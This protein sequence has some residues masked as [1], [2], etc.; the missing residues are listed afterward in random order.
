MHRCLTLLAV[1][2]LATAAQAQTY[3]DRPITVIVPFAAGSAGDIMARGITEVMRERLKQTFVVVNRD[4]AAFT[5]GTAQAAQARPDGY[6]LGFTSTTALTL[7]TKLM[8]DVPYTADALV[9]VCRVYSGNF[10]MAV[11]P[12]SPFQTLA[13]VV[14][15]AKAS[16]GKVSYGVTGVNTPQHIGTM[17]FERVA[18]IQLYNITYRGE[19]QTA[20]AHKAGEVDLVVVTPGYAVTQGFRI[21]GTYAEQRRADMPE[22]KTFREQGFDVVAGSDGGFFVPKGTPEPIRATLQAACEEGTN[23]E[24]YAKIATATRSLA[25]FKTGEAFA[26]Q[27]AAEDKIFAEMIASGAIKP[28]AP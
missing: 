11:K 1:L 23:S 5:L 16:P 4:G 12:E 27:I 25:G 18:G 13:D 3:P 19:P 7:Q 20:P 15:A 17:R 26:Q 14:A 21:L 9:P 6:T 10:V 24:V 28:A 22:V 2:S 8:K